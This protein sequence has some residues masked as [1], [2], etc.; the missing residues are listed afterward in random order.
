MQIDWFTFAAQ[1]A[2]F[3][4][5]VWLLK[6]FLY[7]PI[8]HAMTEREERI[9][10]RF[11]EAREKEA[12]AEAEAAEYR[13]KQEEIESIREKKIKE[14]EREAEE[15]RRELIEKARAEVDRL[16]TEWKKALRREHD[17]FQHDLAQRVSRETLALAR[18]GLRELAHADLE[19]QV[20]RVFID[21]LDALDED[22]REGFKEAVEAETED[23]TI[24]TA[25]EL[26]EDQK[27]SLSETLRD[28]TGREPSLDVERNEEIGFGIE[29]RAGGRKMSW[30]LDSYISDLGD[31][32]R[33][34]IDA[35]IG[36][37]GPPPSPEHTEEERTGASS[38]NSSSEDS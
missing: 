8:V 31:R 16:E 27:R 20:V 26:D 10:D 17:R 3:L 15:R 2:N 34:R 23:V 18:Q 1:I 13:Q 5:L 36:G 29:L 38:S 22:R 19:R 25:F 21:R 14:A 28:L 11:E 6:R 7:G 37:D 4:V 30:G 24:R 35:E 9:A 12:T 33:T 32:I